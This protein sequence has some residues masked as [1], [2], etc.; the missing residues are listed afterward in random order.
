[1]IVTHLGHSCLLVETG[2]ARLLLDPGV[3]SHGFEE[4]TGLD[5]VLI[6]HQH[7]DHVDAERLVPLLEVNDG[8]RLL[9]EPETAAELRAAGIEAESL[10]TAD[11]VALAGATVTGAGSRHAVIHPEVPRVGNVGLLV[12][13]DGEPTLFHPGDSY[14]TAPEGVDVLAVPVNAPWGKVSETIEFTR[15]VGAERLLPIHDGLLVPA[16]REIYLGHVRRLGAGEV[17]DCTGAGPTEF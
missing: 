15:A 13:A 7:P 12:S 10:H 17:V 9:A 6:T 16:A 14:E 4:L 1:M 2:G 8:A 5:A 11:A 3:F